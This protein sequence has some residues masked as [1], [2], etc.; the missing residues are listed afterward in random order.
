MMSDAPWYLTNFI[1][2]R[3]KLSCDLRVSIFQMNFTFLRI[4][5]LISFLFSSS[6]FAQVKVQGTVLDEQGAVLP[7]AL[8]KVL[9]NDSSLLTGTS[10]NS[11]GAYTLTL[12]SQSKFLMQITYSGY[13]GRGQ[14][15]PIN[16]SSTT[17]LQLPAIRLKETS[18]A[19]KQID[20]TTVQQRGEQ[21]GDTT[22]FNA[23]AFKTNPDAT[24]EDL[25]KKMPGITSDNNGVKVNGEAVQRVLVDG[26]PFFGDDPNA[27][28][29]NMPADMIDKVEVFDKMSDQS[30]FSGFNSGDPQKTINLVTK[31]SKMVGQF[32]R[33][34]AGAG[35]D[36]NAGLRYS[37]GAAL[38]NFNG[39]Q[40]ITL[41]L[42][43]NNTNQ[44]NFS[45]ADLSGGMSGGS[46][47]GGRGA[48][49]L[50]TGS[51]N[52]IT[53]TQAAGLNYSDEWGKKINVSG[54]YFFNVTENLASNNL[55]RTFFTE[56]PLSYDQSSRDRNF[57]VNHRGNLRLEYTIDS[58]N[59]LI[60]TPAFSTQN[61]SAKSLLLGENRVGSDFLL[62]STSTDSRNNNQVWDLSNNLLFQHKFKK[63]GR[64]FS[65]NVSSQINDRGNAGRYFA[66]NVYSDTSTSILDQNFLTESY[67]RKTSGNLSYTEPLSAVSQLEITYNPAYSES[68]SDKQTKDYNAVAAD[69][70]NFNSLLSN[71]YENYYITQKAGVSYRYNNKSLSFNFGV[72]GQQSE[73]RGIQFYP[74]TAR[75]TQQF[76]NVLPN[77]MLNY[78]ID[79]TKNIRVFYR[80]STNI[81]SITQLQRVIDISNP[82]QI[83]SGND[84]LRQTF[85]NNLN[86]RYGGFNP[87]TSKNRMIFV[88]FNT[89]SNYISNAT[90]ILKND[91][92][93][94]G[95]QINAGSQLTKPVN[96]DGYYNGRIFFTFG[97][98]MKRLRSNFNLNGGL[99]YAHTPSLIN[100]LLNFSKSYAGNAGFNVS[101]NI[102]EKLDFSV[103]LNG[104]YTIVKNSLQKRSDNQFYSQTATFRINWLF[105]KGFVINSDLSHTLYQG[106]TQSFNQSFISWNAYIGYKFLAKKS[107][108]ARIFV[109]DILNQNR[110]I[111]RTVT[112]AYTEDNFTTVLRRYTMFSLTYTFKK[113]KSGEAPKTEPQQGPNH[114]GMPPGG[115]FR[116]MRPEGGGF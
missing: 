92:L 105:L 76:S 23:A 8:I 91:S 60:F 39:P 72:E 104:N 26:K 93:L 103:G 43:S 5:I 64:T 31:K 7:G 22:Q 6:L 55:N 112:G 4:S 83:R 2:C 107:L 9:K 59:K 100:D 106:L 52:G 61:N 66:S 95:V 19:L 63:K 79:K 24:A 34:Y 109:Y 102:S 99:N 111:S 108:E 21:K 46:S 27:T 11:E 84:S 114:G 110:S 13:S 10:T 28:L 44:Q 71:K 75:V 1:S 67:S 78:K 53:T 98:P 56:N 88:N 47:R 97:Q 3:I 48:S 116:P 37:S 74:Y 50:M 77:A 25:L 62:S 29:K 90:Y 82:L 51:Q 73:L 33:V 41:L 113:F 80:T 65:T 30:A 94:Q 49:P 20:V 45:S 70:S 57:N 18:K 36:E 101:S 16:T 81:P 32:G 12:P 35:T 89:S 15:L 17:S 86:I 68:G 14:F 42:L 58:L 40:R 115:G 54:S 69:Y 38:N 87:Q 85:D 96:L